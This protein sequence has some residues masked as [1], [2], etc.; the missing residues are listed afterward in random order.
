MTGRSVASAIEPEVREDAGL[1]RLVVVRRD[2]HDAVGAGLLAVP[3][4]LDR[5]GG[6]VGA[7]AGDDLRPAGR[8]ILADLDE[9]DLLGVGE[10]GGLAGGAGDDDAVGAGRDHVVDV[11]LD[12][13]PID[14]AV[15]RH[16]RD[17]RDEHLSEGVVLGHVHKAIGSSGCRA[18][19]RRPRPR[20]DRGLAES[21]DDSP[22][23][24]GRTSARHRLRPATRTPRCRPRSTFARI[25]ASTSGQSWTTSA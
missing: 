24:A 1:G 6:L 10:G 12:P 15:R 11:L 13:G 19:S 16:R 23:R 8:D 2:D 7:A 21:R 14:L 25:A 22:R 17:E 18:A 20:R 3:V 4:E 5:V 9:A